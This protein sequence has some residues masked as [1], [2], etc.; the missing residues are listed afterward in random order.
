MNCKTLMPHCK[1]LYATA[2]RTS[3]L[4]NDVGGGQHEKPPLR[5]LRLLVA[6]T[7]DYCEPL[8]DESYQQVTHSSE[9]MRIQNR[10]AISSKL[11]VASIRN[12]ATTFL[13]ST[14]VVNE[15][16]YVCPCV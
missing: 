11:L 6:A 15:G 10:A 8:E 7:V 13:N 5:H 1:P 2:R 12:A 4:P 16:S 9:R 3:S 14:N